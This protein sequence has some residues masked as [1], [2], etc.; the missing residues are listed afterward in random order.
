MA[1]RKIPF[2][3][4]EDYIA[5]TVSTLATRAYE[6]HE[7]HPG[8]AAPGVFSLCDLGCGSGSVLVAMLDTLMATLTPATTPTLTGPPRVPTPIRMH[9]FDFEPTLVDETRRALDVVRARHSAEARSCV[10]V[11]SSCGCVF[12]TDPSEIA[13]DFVYVFWR[14][15]DVVSFDWGT[16]RAGTVVSYK[17]PIAQLADALVDVVQSTSTYRDFEDLYVYRP[18][19]F[20][21][22]GVSR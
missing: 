21:K 4:T 5:D 9:V 10:E 18:A 7:S 17:H 19:A 8:G 6:S 1:H 11:T 16:L 14:L 20:K 22:T 3:E 15:S 13:A 2:R 12:Q